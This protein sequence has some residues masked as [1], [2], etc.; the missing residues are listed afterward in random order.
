[1][2]EI[3]NG[4]PANITTPLTATVTTLTNNGSGA[5]R[6][7][8]SAPHLFG[9][10]DNVN[11]VA[12]STD[13]VYVIS[14][15]SSTQFDLQGSTYT[16]GGSGSATDY[17]LTPAVLLATDGDTFSQQLS[18]ALSSAQ[19]LLD[20]TQFLQEEIVTLNQTSLITQTFLSSG[21]VTVPAGAVV[22]FIKMCGGG[23]GGGGGA[24]GQTSSSECV[25]GG[26]GG[27][28]APLV[29]EMLPVTAGDILSITIG[30]GG[31][32]GTAAN[33]GGG[34]GTT[35]VTDLAS[36][37]TVKAVGSYGGYT[38]PLTSGVDSSEA[39]IPGGAGPYISGANYPTSP[40]YNSVAGQIGFAWSD[41][42]ATHPYPPLP[43]PGGFGTGG[44]V[45]VFWD[46]A[47]PYNSWDGYASSTG[48]AGGTGGG[49]GAFQDTAGG[50]DTNSPAATAGTA[51]AA[52]TGG[53]GGGG[54]GGGSAGSGGFGGAAGGSGGSGM[55][56]ISWFTKENVL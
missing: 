28:G 38:S 43:L 54:G 52:N 11:V 24:A 49:R 51:A 7:S 34:G 39:A 2:S 6:V 31:A 46:N 50:S 14:V 20:R 47:G 32:G 30:A 53:G 22:A 25:G 8:T 26:S 41:T 33:N 23:G 16:A 19:S 56:R 35:I 42:D 10:D 37:A 4:N 48:Y 1:M 12:G 13:G 18:G 44:S 17:S 5:I 9:N 40:I 3:Q 36:S 55:V 15:I 45:L 27:A 21:S 29:T